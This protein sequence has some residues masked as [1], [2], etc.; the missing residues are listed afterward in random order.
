MRVC[1]ITSASFPPEEGIGHHVWNLAQQL[2]CRGHQVG[3]IT[4]GGLAPTALEHRDGIAIWRAPFVACYPYHVHVHGIF[5]NR[6]LERIEGQYD[7]LNAHTPLPPAVH[8]SLP[9]VTTF[10]SPMRSDTAATHVSDLRT[11]AMHL[12]A[13]VAQQIEAALL[14]R[15][16]RITSVASWVAEALRPYG[17]DPAMVTVTGNGVEAC[18]LASPAPHERE[19]IVLSVGRL[20]AGKGLPELVRAARMVVDRHR[21][22]ALRFVLIG[23]GPLLPR[24]HDLVREAGLQGRFDFRGA[25]PAARRDELVRLYQTASAFVLPSHHEGMSTVLLEAMACGMPVISTAVG[26]ALEVVVDGDNGVLVPPHDPGALAEALLTLLEDEPLRQR[27]GRNARAAIA[28]HYTWDA[29][30]ARYV[31]SYEGVLSERGWNRA[32]SS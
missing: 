21:D 14:R 28:R 5:V 25:I 7:L 6:L 23:Q 3:I 20:A 1:L 22:P 27:L 2:E 18:F 4:R 11:L 19:P 10:H 12:Q 9:L 8:T 17:V 24:L 29:V 30:G 13:P 26:G 32:E 15:S 31:A 16:H